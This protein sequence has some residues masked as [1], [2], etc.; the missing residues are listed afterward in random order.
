MR[1]KTMLDVG[2]L[3]YIKLSKQEYRKHILDLFDATA[4]F[5]VKTISDAIAGQKL[6]FELAKELYRIDNESGD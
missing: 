3:R 6:Y 4:Q 5:E 2:K 1:M